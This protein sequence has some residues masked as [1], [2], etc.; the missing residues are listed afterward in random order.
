VRNLRVFAANRGGLAQIHAKQAKNWTFSAPNNW[1]RRVARRR[2]VTGS[3][4][5]GDVMTTNDT[6]VNAGWASDNQGSYL[7]TGDRNADDR[8][9]GDPP[10][11]VSRA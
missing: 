4:Q 6:R 3:E 8:V 5:S 10:G 2:A 1:V 7:K 11:L 9:F